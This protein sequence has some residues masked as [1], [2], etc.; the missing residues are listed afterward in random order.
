M[1]DREGRS[2]PLVAEQ[3]GYGPMGILNHRGLCDSLSRLD[4]TPRSVACAALVPVG[5]IQARV[6]WGP[7]VNSGAFINLVK[8]S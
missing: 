6:E 8:K 1:I 2:C 5:K 4:R 3:S 7:T